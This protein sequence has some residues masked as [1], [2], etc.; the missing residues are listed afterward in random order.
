MSGKNKG[1]GDTTILMQAD[2]KRD[3]VSFSITHIMK[4]IRR[5]RCTL[6]RTT[7]TLKIWEMSLIITNDK[8]TEEIKKR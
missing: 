1:E 7:E 2:Q 3:A 4:R 6:K 5:L 8:R